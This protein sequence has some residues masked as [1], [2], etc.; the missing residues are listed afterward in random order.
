MD[1]ISTTGGKA[2]DA[3][4]DVRGA[5]ASF[6]LPTPAAKNDSSQ[7]VAHGGAELGQPDC[8]EVMFVMDVTHR[9]AMLASHIGLPTDHRRSLRRVVR[10]DRTSRI[11]ILDPRIEAAVDE[12]L[13]LVRDSTRNIVHRAFVTSDNDTADVSRSDDLA[14]IDGGRD[15]PITLLP[16]GLRLHVSAN[17]LHGAS[18]S[19]DD[20][21]HAYKRTMVALRIRL[22]GDKAVDR[23]TISEAFALTPAETTLCIALLEGSSL[24]EAADMSGITMNTARGRLKTVFRKTGAR[25]QGQLVAL[26]AGHIAQA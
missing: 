9:I 12:V 15:T 20:L 5:K 17:V 7:R 18:G 2:R 13:D 1:L 8:S 3:D 19:D 21:T 24:A 14:D 4:R 26:L 11:C 22:G 6:G 10:V 25:R 16:G 23:K